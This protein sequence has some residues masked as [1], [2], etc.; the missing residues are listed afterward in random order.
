MLPLSR[1]KKALPLITATASSVALW[2]FFAM[3]IV[4]VYKA[5]YDLMTIIVGTLAVMVFA[6][7]TTWESIKA[8]REWRKSRNENKKSQC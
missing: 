1:L 6:G 8:Y 5:S 3:W 2:T 4:N 7:S